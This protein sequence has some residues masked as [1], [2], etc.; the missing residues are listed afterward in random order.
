MKDAPARFSRRDMIAAPLAASALYAAPQ[1]PATAPS[2][3]VSVAKI[4]TYDGDLAA[5]FLTMFDQIGGISNQVRGKTVAIKMNLTGGGH[6]DGYTSGDTHWVHPKVA[7]AVTAALGRLGAKRIRILESANGR[8]R[9]ARLE[10]KL[11]AGGWDVAALKNAAP[12][13]EFEDTDQPQGKPYSTLKVGSKPYV[14]PAFNVNRS[15]EDCDFFVSVGKMK[16]HEEMGI[17]LS[18][19]NLFGITPTALYGGREPLFH[20][21]KV[22]APSG[23]PQE[24]DPKS[25]RYEGWRL[26]RILVDINGARPIDLSILDGIT[27]TVGGEGPW[28]PGA[29][30]IKPGLLLAGRNCVSTDAVGAATM[31]YNPRARRDEAPFR[32]FKDPKVHP[33][34]QLIP[35]E[36]S[37]QYADNIM[38]LAEAVGMG[39]ADLSKIDVRGVPIK[40]A[41]FDYEAFWKNQMPKEA[42]KA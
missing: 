10:D 5:Q 4:R 18:M 14:F 16:N 15:Y 1:K 29:K 24:L 20:Y 22:Q 21:G 37:H 36:C 9:N 35:P 17:T 7:G 34:E 30:P 13:V 12:V 25:N 40:D 42:P 39:S 26:P 31:G 41:M 28:V 27:A 19:K 32:V 3:P 2:Q 6:F 33:P 11:L 8:Q 23:A 38:L